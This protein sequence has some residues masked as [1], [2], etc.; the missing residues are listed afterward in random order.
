MKSKQDQTE[1]VSQ[2]VMPESI[3]YLM[4]KFRG[5]ILFPEKVKRDRKFLKSIKVWPAE[6]HQHNEAL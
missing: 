2:P 4:E 5:K 6:L 1:K 3:A